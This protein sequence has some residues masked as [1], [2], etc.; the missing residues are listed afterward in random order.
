MEFKK[1]FEDLKDRAEKAALRV[2]LDETGFRYV[3][4]EVAE[5]TPDFYENAKKDKALKKAEA[6][7]KKKAELEAKLAELTKEVK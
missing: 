6:L 3:R 2:R 7:A 5:S 1:F 4:K